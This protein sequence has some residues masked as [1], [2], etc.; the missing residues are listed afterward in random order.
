MDRNEYLS[1]V[2][3]SDEFESK[4]RRWIEQIS[5][6]ESLNQL[7]HSFLTRAMMLN[8]AYQWNWLGVPIIKLPEDIVVIQEFIT[9]FKPTAII[10]IGVARGGG[11]KFYSSIQRLCGISPNV[12]GVDIK[13]FPHTLEALRDDLDKSIFLVEGDSLSEFVKSKIVSF[14]ENHSKVFVILDGD[15]SHTHVL[16]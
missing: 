12:L 11:V 14:V 5:N 6:D 15:H 2:E 13:F 10:E 16:N 1:E 7:G 3:N 8:Y 9:K 4:R